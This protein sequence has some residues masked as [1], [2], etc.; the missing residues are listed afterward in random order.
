MPA[1]R[2]ARLHLNGKKLSVVVSTYHPSYGRKYKIGGSLCK[3]K[4]IFKIIRV[5]RAGGVV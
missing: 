4:I 2:Y 1:K 5:K 3:N